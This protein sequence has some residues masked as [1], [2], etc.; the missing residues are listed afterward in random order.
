MFSPLAVDRCLHCLVSWIQGSLGSPLTPHLYTRKNQH[1]SLLQSYRCP[2]PPRPCGPPQ[3]LVFPR[4]RL[5]SFGRAR[6]QSYRSHSCPTRGCVTSPCGVASSCFFDRFRHLRHRLFGL[7]LYH[8]SNR[9]NQ[10]SRSAAVNVSRVLTHCPERFSILAVPYGLRTFFAR[11]VAGVTALVFTRTYWSVCRS[12]GTRRRLLGYTREP[13]ES[14][15][16]NSVVAAA[17]GS[18]H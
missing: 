16:R 3:R 8:R 7:L 14:A 10:L 18:S 4:G 9:R 6:H 17:L 2:R 15:L 1:T 5:A 13:T 11:T 12:G